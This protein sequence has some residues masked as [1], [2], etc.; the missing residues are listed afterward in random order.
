MQLDLSQ[1][2]LRGDYVQNRLVMAL[3]HNTA[4]TSLNLSGV[5][6]KINPMNFIPSFTANICLTNVIYDKN[7]NSNAAK[8]INHYVQLNV[9]IKKVFHY[10]I[11]YFLYIN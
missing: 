10:L 3:K 11:N 5:A 4:L 2:E 1:E 6:W 9:N 8:S 7:F